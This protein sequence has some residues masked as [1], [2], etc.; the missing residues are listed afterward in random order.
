MEIEATMF[1][2]PDD[3]VM[4]AIAA[5]QKP[6]QW[7]IAGAALN[8]GPHNPTHQGLVQDYIA[9]PLTSKGFYYER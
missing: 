9:T 5:K 8:G 4:K 6:A 3:E 7:R 2:Q 1:Y